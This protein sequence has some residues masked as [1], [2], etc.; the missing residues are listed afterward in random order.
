MEPTILSLDDKPYCN[1][2]FPMSKSE[3][4]TLDAKPSTYF[5]QNLFGGRIAGHWPRCMLEQLPKRPRDTNQLAKFI[6][7]LTTGDETEKPE[8]VKAQSGRKGGLIGGKARKDALT[9]ERR[10]E[11]AMKAA[12][13]R[14]VEPCSRNRVAL[15]VLQLLPDT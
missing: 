12:K 10:S 13:A 1:C 15:Y 3:R 11:I 7:D 4:L 5:A 8:S 9:P 2:F 6:V 14:W